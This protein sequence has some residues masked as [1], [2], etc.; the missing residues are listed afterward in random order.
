MNWY[1]KVLKQYADFNGRARRQEFW[2]FVLFNFKIMKKI[3]IV[4]FALMFILLTASDCKNIEKEDNVEIPSIDQIKSDLL[5]R[6]L[7]TWTF[8]DIEEFESVEIISDTLIN[9]N[10]LILKVKL[11]LIGKNT[12]RLYDG[13]LQINYVISEN[14]LTWEFDGFGGEIIESAYN[15][16]IINTE[17]SQDFADDDIEYTEVENTIEK[18]EREIFYKACEMCGHEFKYEKK[19]DSFIG[20]YYEGGFAYCNKNDTYSSSRGAQHLLFGAP[21]PKYCG[22]ICACEAEN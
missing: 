16:E 20:Y 8:A 22:Q 10:E 5:D 12:K 18:S 15:S 14:G 13:N 3:K 21:I 6:K 1:L 9:D 2:M 19:Y 7:D 17:E 4:I 11:D